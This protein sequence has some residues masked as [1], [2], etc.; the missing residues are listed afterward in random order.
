MY[1]DLP[2]DTIVAALSYISPDTTRA[3]WVTIGM[4]IKSELGDDGFAV[5]DDWSSRANN[6]RQR[7]ARDTWRS[8]HASGGV[9]IAT[10]IHMAKQAGYVPEAKPRQI[11]PA[12]AEERRRK[13][14]ADAKRDAEERERRYARAAAAAEAMWAE[15]EPHLGGHAYLTRKGILQPGKV[16]VGVY[17][18]WH[19]AE[20]EDEGREIEV[21]GALLIPIRDA[22]GHMTSV[23]AIFP[24]AMNPLGRDRD[25]LP[26]GRKQSCYFNIG[27]PSGREAEPVY[28]AEGYATAC[29]IVEASGGALVVVAFDAGNLEPIAKVMREKLPHAR[30]IICA[31][32]DQFSRADGSTCNTGVISATAAAQAVGGLVA[33]PQFR[34]L[35]G[36]PT[37]FNDLHQCEGLQAVA[38]QLLAAREP[39]QPANDNEA[40]PQPASSPAPAAPPSQQFGAPIDVF[41]VAPPP[42]MPL[43]V[44]PDVL[45]AYVQDQADLTGCDPIIIGMSALVAAA[46]VID[47]AIQLQP[48]RRDPTWTERPCLWLAVV[49]DPSTMKTP[50]ISKA[51]RHVKRID[52]LWADEN[53]RNMAS[54][55]FQHESWKEAKKVEKGLPEPQQPATKRLVVEDITVEALSDVLKDN[56]RGVLTLKDE[57]TGW[58]ASMDAY[59]SSAKGASMDR[60]HWLQAYNGGEHMV[61]R[62]SRGRVRVPNWSTCIIGGI[63]PDMI[64]RVASSMGNDG[65]LQRFM[66]IVAR[67]AVQDADRAPDMEA[68]REFSALFD[69]LVGIMSGEQAIT[70]TE[71]AHQCR[72]RVAEY[73]KRMIAAFDHPHMQAWL[74]KWT[75]LFG[76]LL[77]TYH[78]IECAT[79][80][81]HPCDVRVSGDTAYKVERLMMGTLLPHAIHFY[82][83]ILD[84]NERQEHVRQLARLIL[85]KRFDRI[86]KRDMTQFWK[87]S[88]ALEWWEVRQIVD[89]LCTLDWLAPDAGSIDTDGRPRAWFVNPAVHE[90]Y[91]KQ[92]AT[93][94]ERR[95]QVAETIREARQ[96]YG[97]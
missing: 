71:E 17:R 64:R 25:Y 63:Q 47:D 5:W 31:D 94:A 36:E 77:T 83:E 86:S 68:M 30:L 2:I 10:L 97:T 87:A 44:L 9:T 42:A 8:I 20:G 73:S 56:R 40:G 69:K 51:V 26:G 13:R 34:S 88:R 53:D 75:G 19:R 32:N 54:W 35:E 48:K 76:R 6:Y 79:A 18:R 28:I 95:R 50:A 29:S 59:K 72:E 57:L 11:P 82:T 37:D 33:V 24:D 41:G 7:D 85:A 22:G 21:P 92:A 15:A 39:G 14:E 1:A 12:E 96:N 3:E 89:S 52:R 66:I 93:E 90:A 78:V 67:P 62:V 43:D 91:S 23:Q 60:A 80:G 84:A 4:A 49:G 58:F 61:D 45:Q 55:K 74:G 70:L 27:R 16:R 81:R 46:A 38:H 65:L